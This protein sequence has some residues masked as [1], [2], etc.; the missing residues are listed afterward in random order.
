MKRIRPALRTFGA[1]LRTPTLSRSI[2]ALLALAILLLLAVNA[3]TYV[4]IQRTSAY[5]DTVDHSQQV[6]LAAK[7]VLG[8][9]V[10]AETGQRGFMLT[11]RP[12]YLKVHDRAVAQL[13]GVLARLD[14]LIG[15]DAEL[16]PRLERVQALY[17]ERM[18]LMDHTIAL[19][20][21]G[22]IGEAVSL[23]R[24]GRGKVLMD[25]MR[26]EL[27][28][29]DAVEARRLAERTRQSERA[30]AVTV[31]VNALAALLI[32]ILAGISTWLVRRYVEEIESARLELDRLNAG[33]EN[34]VRDRTAELTRAN[35]EIQRFAYIV[36][37]DLRSPLV[38]VMG[39]TSELE[40]IGK[41]FDH[42]LTQLEQTHP[43]A[44]EPE[45][46]RAVREDVPEAV[47]FIRASTA[48]MDRLINAILK[49][50]REGRR[51]LAPEPLD[52]TALVRGIAD[53]L[54][55]QVSEAG[56]EIIVRD[57]PVLES[58]R[59][60][61]EQ[62]FG[63][64]LD[65]AV[66][67]QQP[68]RPIRILA[69]G[70]QTADGWLHYRITDNGRG[71]SE[72]DHERIFELFRRAGKQ[73]LPGEGLGLAFVR[74]SV[75]RLGGTITLESELGQGS[76]FHLKFPTRLIVLGEAGDNL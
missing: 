55:H 76:T 43:D 8:L 46:I 56:G 28:A 24:S 54:N 66:K 7:D 74:N 69:E 45:A 63:N 48:K 51:R 9:L 32:L 38:N 37:H 3:A 53:S 15:A 23:I 68:G 18:T 21:T 36:S 71:V 62:I 30:S 13:P 59:F 50:S 11:A 47:G 44:I 1:F 35:E 2:I 5:N 10:D 33:L 6:R 41:I 25:Q 27:T 58:D 42:Q 40:Q 17:R 67:Y 75:R 73:D 61:I 57:L 31:S 72:R 70:H 16:A 65:N 64:L 12:E 29:I 14:G 20:R 22:R 52:M 34:Q 39:Y 26:I 60:S 49:L 19:T 4:M